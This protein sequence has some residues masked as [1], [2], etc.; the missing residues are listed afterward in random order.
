ML[1]D[2]STLAPRIDHLLWLLI[3]LSGAIVLLVVALIIGFSIKYR[4]GSTAK[5]GQLP[6]WLAR[7]VEIGWTAA[8]FFVAIFLFWFAATTETSQYEVPKD[9]MEVHV[10]AKQWMWKLEHPNGRREINALH[11]PVGVPVRLVMTSQDVIHSFFV[12]AFR[13]KQDVLPGRYTE[14]WFQATRPGTYHLLCAEYCGTD[15]SQMTGGIVVMPRADYARW[16]EGTDDTGTLAQQ[17][18]RLFQRLGCTGCHGNSARVRAPSLNGVYGR[19]QPMNDGGFRRADEQYLHDSIVRPQKDVVAGYQPVMPSYQG[20]ASEGD[21]ILLIAY[22][23]SPD[24]G[25]VQ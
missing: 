1:P 20:I 10:V 15:H 11:I 7:D 18:A 22:L 19:M 8:I 13:I 24:G 12:P 9:A 3:G 25:D 6:G 5:R 16:S 17:G 4:R 23:K 14:T 21:I 2:A